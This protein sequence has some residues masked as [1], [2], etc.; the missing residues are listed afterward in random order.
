M[1]PQTFKQ[2]INSQK[3]KTNRK[4]LISAPNK[5]HSETSSLSEFEVLNSNTPHCLFC[6]ALR[7]EQ[8]MLNHHCFPPFRAECTNLEGL[9]AHVQSIIEKGQCVYCELEFGC[10][11]SA[12]QHM[13][14]VGH[15]KLDLENFAPFEP[16]YL[17]KVE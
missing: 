8:H 6:P 11:D 15:G 10:A 17:W 5:D 9:I 4:N 7:T 12:K 14:D 1:S 3:H 16:Y 2:H 13:A